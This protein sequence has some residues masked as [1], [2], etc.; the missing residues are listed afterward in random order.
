MASVSL[1]KEMRVLDIVTL[2]PQASD[3]MAE[4]GL[5][6][7]GCAVGGLES[8][9]EGCRAHGYGD[10]EIAAL[11]QDIEDARRTMALRPATIDVTA[12]AARAVR[13]I[14]E[15]EGKVR[16]GSWQKTGGL[17]VIV[18]GDGGF[19][20]EFRDEPTEGDRTFMNAEEPDV[21]VFASMLTLTR[22]GGATIDFRDGRFKLDLPEDTCACSPHHFP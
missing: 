21:R 20:M 9:E 10:E 13:S 22:I 4:W 17:A 18:D 7:S 3:V 15:K 11:L 5:H 14:A 1:N 19:C 12:P 16:E 6:C 2:V 8:L